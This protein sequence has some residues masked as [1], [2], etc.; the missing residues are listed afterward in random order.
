MNKP[1]N[2]NEFTL[3]KKLQ[4]HVYRILLLSDGRLSSQYD[5]TIKIHNKD[6]LDKI[7]ISIKSERQIAD[8]LELTDKS[9]MTI[10][11][12]VAKYGFNI[13]KVFGKAYSL[14]YS[15]KM[16]DFYLFKVI[17]LKLNFLISCN[18]L[19][20][21]KC[22]LTLWEFKD[23]NDKNNKYIK[24]SSIKVAKSEIPTGMDLI[25]IADDK[26]VTVMGRQN[27]RVQFWLIDNYTF[28]NYST[29]TNIELP[30]GL[31]LYDKNTL[32][33]G[34]SSG[35][36]NII[37]INT[38]QV[39][40][41][42][43]YA[44]GNFNSNWVTSL[45]KLSNGNIVFA[46]TNFNS[47]KIGKSHKYYLVEYEFGKEVKKIRSKVNCHVNA[48]STIVELKNGCIATSGCDSIKIWK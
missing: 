27:T 16:N 47:N 33:I 15:I 46:Y 18:H 41:K 14:K 2:K 22:E 32:F 9:V 7:D 21:D 43:K 26:I 30:L 13:Y 39:T 17:E 11:V 42:F 48:I 29:L 8:Y 38:T 45:I 28:K 44:E 36:I 19:E 23:K 5:L 10:M 34:N 24:A 3:V 35:F 25:K 12:I 1:K 31:F 4:E 20:Q 6:D 37:N 40:A